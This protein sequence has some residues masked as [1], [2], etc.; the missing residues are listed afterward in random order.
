MSIFKIKENK[1]PSIIGKILKRTPKE[2]ALIEINNLFVENEGDLTKVRL[3][4][5]EEI[6]DKFKLKLNKKFRTLR[7]DLFRKYIQ[8]CLEDHVI[9]DNEINTFLH[10]KKLLYLT[11]GEIKQILSL[12]TK[13]LYDQ[14]V[15]KAIV[16]GEL[17]NEEKGNLELLKK[18]LL[19]NDQVA[20]D[21]FKSNSNRIF[22]YFINDAISDERLSDE[23]FEKMN[24][25]SLSLGIEPNLNTRTKENLER[26]RL[27]WII[28]NG[29]LPIYPNPPINIQKS[30]SLY[31]M[32]Q[33]S[34]K[35]Q[36]RVTKRVNYSGPTAR[37]KIAKGVY[38]RMGSISAKTISED[39]WQVIDSGTIYLTNKRLIF[40]GSRGNKTIQITKILDICPYKNGVDIQKDAGKSPFLEFNR[41]VD[42]FS[43]MLVRL[44]N[45]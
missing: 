24:E 28:E 33:V 3:E 20:E 44:M 16:D 35:E 9:D 2:N 4:Q 30:E 29:E 36:R 13:N 1:K 43:M 6:T 26:Y 10:L 41:N 42:I 8:H 27:Y 31:F 39:V 7:L 37:I 21:I 11:E 17:T 34:W 15:K 22:N 25:I 23:E 45:K 14:E 40:M 18:N 32:A 12:E 19:I 5:I 38:Y